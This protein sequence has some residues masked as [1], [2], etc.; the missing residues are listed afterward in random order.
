MALMYLVRHGSNDYLGKALAGRLPHVHLN[1]QGRAEAECL[2]GE[3]S[4]KGI[5]RII[6]S[7]LDRCRETAQPLAR[8]LD[9]EVEI[10]AEVHEV[11]FGDWTGKT[12]KELDGLEMWQKFTTHRSGARI[13]NGETMLQVQCRIVAFLDELWRIPGVG[14]IAIFSHGDPIRAALAYYLGMP[15]DFLTRLEVS[16]GSYSVLDLGESQPQLVKLNQLPQLTKQ[17]ASRSLSLGFS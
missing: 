13:P 8:R 10:S 4:P 15:L 12:M 6:S 3:L 11:D 5:Q 2:A 9:L 16:P 1:D 7:P 17:G 14:G